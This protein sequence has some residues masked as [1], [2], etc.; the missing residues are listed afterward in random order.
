V[1]GIEVMVEGKS[2]PRKKFGVTPRGTFSHLQRH[3]NTCHGKPTLTAMALG[4][5][6]P[7][8]GLLPAG[9]VYFDAFS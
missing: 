7:E 2:I 3:L 9:T 8:G 1:S 6:V 4:D 5:K